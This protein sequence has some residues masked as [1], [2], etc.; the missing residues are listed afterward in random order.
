VGDYICD[1]SP[2][3]ATCQ[4]WKWTPHWERGDVCVKYHPCVVF[5]FPILSFFV[6]PNFTRVA[7]QN[8]RTDFYAV[9]FIW[10]QFWVIA[11]LEGE[12]LRKFS[13]PPILTQKQ[14]KR[15]VNKHF[16][17]KRANYSNFCVIK[18]TNAI[19]TKFCTVIKTI[20]FLL[21]VVPKCAP[22]ILK[23]EK[24]RYSDTVWPTLT[25]FYMMAHISRPELTRCSKIQTFKNP[26]WRTAAI[27]KIVQ[28][29]ISATVLL[30][31]M[32]FG[33]TMHIRP[34]S[35]TVDQKFQNPRWRTVA[36]LKIK[37]RDIFKTVWPIMMKF[38]MMT[39]ISPLDLTSCLK[40]QTA[41]NYRFWWNLY[42]DAH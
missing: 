23:I 41:T 7:R 33:T 15:G 18:T 8:R 26:G 10:R 13:F 39:H 2:Q 32:K 27:L 3:R 5:S 1:D 30:I 37:T 4:N 11:F 14:P 17:A 40:N 19:A 35:L 38:C 9:C 22:H 20:K 31:S 36:I 34:P 25:K 28:C 21:W 24:S 12:E 42:D 29:D 16:Q 6:A